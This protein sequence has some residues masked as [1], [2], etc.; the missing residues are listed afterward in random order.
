MEIKPPK[1]LETYDKDPHEQVIDYILDLHAD[2]GVLYDGRMMFLF[3]RISERCAPLV[4]F[5]Q[6]WEPF[7][8]FGLLSKDSFPEG[9]KNFLSSLRNFKDL[10][11]VER[12]ELKSLPEGEVIICASEAESPCQWIGSRGRGLGCTIQCLETCRYKQ[13]QGTKVFCIVC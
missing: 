1:S 8:I 13:I 5:W 9:L 10:S 3:H 6:W 2:Y 7:E 11:L 4:Y 12:S